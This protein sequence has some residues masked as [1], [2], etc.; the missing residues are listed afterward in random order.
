MYRCG[1]AFPMQELIDGTTFGTWVGSSAIMMSRSSP[2]HVLVAIEGLGLTFKL[3]EYLTVGAV[4]AFKV[5]KERNHAG[6][7]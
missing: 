6:E 4:D 7:S 1:V 5:F 3:R 2:V